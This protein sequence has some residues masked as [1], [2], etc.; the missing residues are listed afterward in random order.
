MGFNQ[1][2]S[3]DF[4]DFSGKISLSYAVNDNNNIYALY[5]EGFK[6]GGFQHDARSR[7]QLNTGLVDSETATNLEIGWKGSYDNIRFAVTLFDME[8]E[9]A[10]INNLINVSTGFTTF[11]T[12]AGGVENTGIE[13][14]ATWAATENL[15]IGG[16]LASYD[17]KLVDA[18]QGSALDT[19]TGIVSG[20]DIS[21]LVPN[22]VP[23]ETFTI[24]A[25]YQWTL[26]GGSTIGLRAD[27]RHRGTVWGRAGGNERQTLTLDGTRPMFQRPEIDKIGA[28]ISWTSA[29]GGT[30]IELWGRNLDDDYDWI[31]W[32]PGSPANYPRGPLA[33]G[34]TNPANPGTSRPRGVAGRTQVGMTAR[35]LF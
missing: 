23:E 5:S 16:S 14:E 8:L 6:A 4:D 35:F 2:I 10:Q 31:N 33:A 28:S 21:G 29:S 11:V 22:Y 13:L 15:T 17:S 30:M 24:Y 19:D 20:E 25:D 7:T 27:L 32:G 9:D 34:T 26:S 18:I 1:F 3:R 12:N